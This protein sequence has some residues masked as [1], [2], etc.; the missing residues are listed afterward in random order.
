MSSEAGA[1]LIRPMRPEDW[2]EVRAIFIEGIETGQATFEA[3]APEWEKFNASRL[4]DH[5]FVAEASGHVLGWTA[6]SPVSARPA[7]AGVVEHSVYRR[8]AGYAPA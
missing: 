6:V 8:M 1:V 2:P 3:A 7:Y 5:R 4:S